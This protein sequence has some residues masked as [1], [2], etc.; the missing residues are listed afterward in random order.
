MTNRRGV[1]L[2]LTVL[3]GNGHHDGL[4]SSIKLLACVYNFAFK[5]QPT[6]PRNRGRKSTYDRVRHILLR[7]LPLHS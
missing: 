5:L 2:D 7:A 4:S 6:D 3:D 1:F